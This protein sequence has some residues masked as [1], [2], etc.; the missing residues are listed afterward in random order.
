L[1]D[2]L[3]TSTARG[4]SVFFALFLTPFVLVGV[5]LVVLAVTQALRLSNPRPNVTVSTA[6]VALGEQLGVDWTLDGRVAK[7]ARLTITLE[8]REEATYR[9]GTDTQ[10]DRQ[11]FAAIPV[12]S[13]EG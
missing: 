7:L 6:A 11:V 13:Q 9:R 5:L 8:G 2:L 10:T 12:A 4:F 3:F 1:F